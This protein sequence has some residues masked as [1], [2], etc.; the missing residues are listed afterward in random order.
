MPGK[1]T[2][3]HPD[4]TPIFR[5]VTSA[6]EAEEHLR[7]IRQAMERSTKHSTLSGLSGVLAG[8]YALAAAVFAPTKLGTLTDKLLFVALWGA[9][10]VLALVTD[11]LLT[12]RRAAKVGKTAFSALGV[13]L[14]RAVA[15]GLLA[16]AGITLFHLLHPEA[17]GTYLY[18]LWILCYAVAL[19][20]IAMFSRREVSIMG[21]AFLGAGIIALLLPDNFI[22]GPRALM[23]LTFGGFHIVYGAWMGLKYG[24]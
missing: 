23:A 19:L 12:K 14:A 18:G 22:I 24:W 4:G 1:E 8:C 3:F 2:K 6:G 13:H 5:I 20:A 15:P 21:W 17:L 9:T 11:V 16:G 10:L 7:V